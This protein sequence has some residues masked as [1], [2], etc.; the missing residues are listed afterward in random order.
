ME[1]Q[2]ANRF[3]I[4]HYYYRFCKIDGNK[5]ILVSMPEFRAL[6]SYIQADN[7]VLQDVGMS[8]L[9]RQ[10]PELNPNGG[11]TITVI[12]DPFENER[13]M[14]IAKCRLDERFVKRIGIEYSLQHALADL[15]GLVDISSFI[16]TKYD[17]ELLVKFMTE[18]NG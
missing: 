18:Y 10:I 7:S 15:L 4:K 3:L 16:K 12:Y 9:I 1:P 11:Y 14:G 5:Q 17:H 2:E 8:H 6:R 13:Y